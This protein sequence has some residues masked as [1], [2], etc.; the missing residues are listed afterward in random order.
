M[1]SEFWVL[2]QSSALLVQRFRP[3][4]N[5]EL[6]THH[7]FQSFLCWLNEVRTVQDM[8]LPGYGLHPLKGKLAG[9]WSVS[10]SG[11]WRIVFQ[12]EDG[13]AHDVDLIDYH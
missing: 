11:N 10:V 6:R 2:T 13:M 7:C 12:F 3:T 9:F 8:A 5:P 1:S 4:Q